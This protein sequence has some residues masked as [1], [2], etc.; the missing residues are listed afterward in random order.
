MKTIFNKTCSH[1][2]RLYLCLVISCCSGFSLN[3][4]IDQLKQRLSLPDTENRIDLFVDLVLQCYYFES[5]DSVAKYAEMSMMLAE[6]LDQPIALAKAH[7]CKGVAAFAAGQPKESLTETQL[8]L[9]M[10]KS[11]QDTLLLLNIRNLRGNNYYD[12]GLLEMAMEEYLQAIHYAKQL[13]LTAK[14]AAAYGNMARILFN[15]Q[16]YHEAKRYYTL[17]A[18]LGL[19]TKDTL[20]TIGILMNKVSTHLKLNELD[21]A[22]ILA[23]WG[24]QRS[25]E[26]DFKNGVSMAKIRQAHLAIRSRHYERALQLVQDMLDTVVPNDYNTRY[27]AWYFRSIALDSLRQ[28][29]LA[30]EAAEEALRYAALTNRKTILVAANRQLYLTNKHAGLAE[31]AL[32]YYEAY[33]TL[34]DTILDSDMARKLTTMKHLY[35]REQQNY[36]I[37]ELEDTVRFEKLRSRQWLLLLGSALAIVS[38]AGGW[39][40]YVK[41]QKTI[42]ERQERQL[43]E[44][45]LLSLQ[46]NP[47]FLFNTLTSLQRYLLEKE[48]VETAHLY[49]SKLSQL[50]RNLLAHSR[51]KLIPLED[52][53]QNLKAYLQLQKLRFKGKLN[54][55]LEVDEQITSGDYQVPP[56]LIQPLVE[57]AIEHAG[58][59]SKE[60][61]Q[62]LIHIQKT[63]NELRIL[64][65]DNGTGWAINSNSSSDNAHQG[66]ALQIV[67]DRLALL[68][69]LSQDQHEMKIDTAIGQGTTISLHLPFY[70][71]TD[72]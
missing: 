58:I 59:T 71:D 68:S 69:K 24:L 5:P 55:Q 9:E 66:L 65:S 12:I 37:N 54:Y 41:Q 10:A 70:E 31:P 17:A 45:K 23:E 50:M 44:Q 3:G 20:R 53:L 64:V 56:M 13:Q 42:K 22:Q 57:N 7:Y 36:Q 16:S 40:F 39:L 62:L 21:S 8:A 33:R 35:E 46:M 15:K 52:E 43:I 6:K 19:Q 29:P 48:K 28:Y 1:S 32:T 34:E 61:G 14:A 11:V 25:T 26:L 38:L 51:E 67:K 63:T 60:E 4:Q 49:L 18:D 30:I 2:I 27:N 72:Y 47:H